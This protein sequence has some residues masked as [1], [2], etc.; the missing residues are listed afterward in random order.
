MRNELG[1]WR[2]ANGDKAE[3]IE[4]GSKSSLVFPVLCFFL[5]NGVLAYDGA[6]ALQLGKRLVETALGGGAVAKGEREE[7]RIEVVVIEG[8]QF[9]RE[10]RGRCATGREPSD[11]VGSVRFGYSVPILL[12]ARRAWRLAVRDRLR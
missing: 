9:E 11:R 6:K 5:A 7:C 10:G 8:I 4:R 3:V 2:G 12:R 1:R